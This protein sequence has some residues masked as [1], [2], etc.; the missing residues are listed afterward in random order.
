[1]F[2]IEIAGVTVGINNRYSYIWWLCRDYIIHGGT[3]AFT[4]SASLEELEREHRSSDNSWGQDA[5]PYYESL[6]LYRKLCLG[7]IDHDGFLMHSAVIGVNGQAIA[8]AAKSGV[9][10]STHIQLWQKRY[11]ADIHI[12]N[13]DKPIYRLIDGQIYACGTPWQGK[14][15]W[16]ENTKAPLKALCFLERGEENSLEPL[17]PNA[18]LPRLFHQLLLP[19]E[20][21]TMDR[22]LSLIDR[23]LDTTPCWLLRCNKTLTAAETARRALIGGDT[24]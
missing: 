6:C 20:Q 22:F 10:K 18:A 14:E 1:M 15:F 4:V 11:G 2:Q 21:Q 5:L 19:R 23:M 9:G 12:I 17:A 13:G 16:G 8:F 3:A 24:I 7:I